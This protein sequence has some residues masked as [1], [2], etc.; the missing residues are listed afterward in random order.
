MTE[1]MV[2]MNYRRQRRQAIE[3]ARAADIRYCK[4]L[5]RRGYAPDQIAAKMHKPLSTILAWINN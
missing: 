2:M 3:D 1:A 4:E 5:R